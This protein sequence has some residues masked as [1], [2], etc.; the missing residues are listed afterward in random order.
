MANARHMYTPVVQMGNS[1]FSR[2]SVTGV[3]RGQAPI[4]GTQKYNSN[5]SLLLLQNSFLSI[6][7]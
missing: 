6:P 4:K 7:F 1:L 2:V 3:H 5:S